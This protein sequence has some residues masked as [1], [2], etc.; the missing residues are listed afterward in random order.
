MAV[1]LEEKIMKKR[2][3]H[4]EEEAV[5]EMLHYHEKKWETEDKGL[6]KTGD[7]ALCGA[8]GYDFLAYGIDCKQPDGMGGGG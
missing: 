5:N 4:M 3:Q 2:L 7:R 8:Q 6:H 1:K